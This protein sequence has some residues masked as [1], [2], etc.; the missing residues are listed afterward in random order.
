MSL[1]LSSVGYSDPSE[2]HVSHCWGQTADRLLG[3]L[4][5][6]TRC[7]KLWHKKYEVVMC[8]TFQ[9]FNSGKEGNRFPNHTAL[10]QPEPVI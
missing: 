8:V 9:K 7:H 6:V 2:P 4:V 1:A 5:L 3:R 10:Q